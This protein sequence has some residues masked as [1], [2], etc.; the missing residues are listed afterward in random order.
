MLCYVLLEVVAVCMMVVA[1]C[2]MV[3]A[4]SMMIVASCCS[5]CDVFCRIPEYNNTDTQ[6][7]GTV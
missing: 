3:V 5:L 7:Y 6:N 2:M 4:V 1:V